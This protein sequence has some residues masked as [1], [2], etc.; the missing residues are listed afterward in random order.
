MLL[1]PTTTAA[2]NNEWNNTGADG[3]NAS[4]IVR[5]QQFGV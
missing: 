3:M 1:R 5:D 4:I 2:G